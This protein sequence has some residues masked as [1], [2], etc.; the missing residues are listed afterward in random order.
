MKLPPIPLNQSATLRLSKLPIAQ[1]I[2]FWWAARLTKLNT[3]DIIITE[4]YSANQVNN[5]LGQHV[6]KKVNNM[7]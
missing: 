6:Y 7:E 4:V 1:A 3:I 5:N 2:V